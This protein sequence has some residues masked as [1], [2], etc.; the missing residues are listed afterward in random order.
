M[1]FEFYTTL[2]LTPSKQTLMQKN[3]EIEVLHHVLWGR[4]DIQNICLN[5][6][7]TPQGAFKLQ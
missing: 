6:K 5:V 4:K 3:A 7:N 1:P 2:S